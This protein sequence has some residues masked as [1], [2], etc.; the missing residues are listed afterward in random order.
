MGIFHGGLI[1]LDLIA[2]RL[3]PSTASV[4]STCIKEFIKN[5]YFTYINVILY[6]KVS[7]LSLHNVFFFV[8]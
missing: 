3:H 7:V 4:E 8:C 5:R 6:G 1:I 2:L